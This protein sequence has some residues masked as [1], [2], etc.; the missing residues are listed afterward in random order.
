MCTQPLF[1]P[2]RITFHPLDGTSVRSDKL[3]RELAGVATLSEDLLWSAFDHPE[4]IPEDWK[5]DQDGKAQPILFWGTLSQDRHDGLHRGCSYLSGLCWSEDQGRWGYA[6]Y[7]LNRRF[8]GRLWMVHHQ[9]P[10]RV[11]VL[12]H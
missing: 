12:Q 4:L 8:L 5:F 6:T 7:W 3:L 10:F 1:D 2:S 11:A 9:M